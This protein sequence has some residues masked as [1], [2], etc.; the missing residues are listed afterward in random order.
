MMLCHTGGV[1]KSSMATQF[2]HNKHVFS[3]QYDATVE[4]LLL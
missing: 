2:V 1:G 3:D 4:G